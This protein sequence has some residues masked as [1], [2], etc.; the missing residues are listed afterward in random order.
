MI[1][2]IVWAHL[3]KQQ[4]KKVLIFCTELKDV[5]CA[6]KSAMYMLSKCIFLIEG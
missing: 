6:Y 1:D 3:L 5:H 4:E 2:F